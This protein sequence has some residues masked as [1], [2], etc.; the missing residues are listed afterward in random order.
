LDKKIKGFKRNKN[1]AEKVRLPQ[2]PGYYYDVIV[3]SGEIKKL[4]LHRI[5]ELDVDLKL[6]LK[7]AGITE[8][9]FKKTYLRSPDPVS[10]PALRQSHLISLLEVLGIDLKIRLIVEKDLNNVR[11]EHLKYKKIND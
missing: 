7:E 5:Q 11:T 6:V 4:I 1:S 3:S 9:A 8:H 10:T 2:S